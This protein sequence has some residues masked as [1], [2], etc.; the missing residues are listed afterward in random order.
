MN[1]FSKAQGTQKLQVHNF[2]LETTVFGNTKLNSIKALL[3]D[4]Y[5]RSSLN[6]LSILYMLIRSCINM[7]L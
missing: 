4:A 6:E 1:A 2:H 7:E 5:P 3:R